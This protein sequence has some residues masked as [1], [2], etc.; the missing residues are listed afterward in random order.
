[1]FVC[2][3]FSVFVHRKRPCDE[4]I[5]RQGVLPTVQDLENRSE[6]ESFIEVGQGPNLGCSAKEKKR[7]VTLLTHMTVP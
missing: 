3:R 4:L 7:S 6:T 5:T 2:V 1:V